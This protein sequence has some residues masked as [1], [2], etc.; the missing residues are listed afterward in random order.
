MVVLFGSLVLMAVLMLTSIRV[1]A[2][3]PD[4]DEDD[5]EREPEEPEEPEPTPDEEEPEG[6]PASE[7]KAGEVDKASRAFAEQRRTIAQQAREIEDLNSRFKTI[8]DGLQSVAGGKKP[9]EDRGQE[10]AKVEVNPHDPVN[11]PHKAAEWD[12]EQRKKL[13]DTID[14]R[15]KAR[16]RREFVA[17]RDNLSNAALDAFSEEYPEF[18][19]GGEGRKIIFNEAMRW[20]SRGVGNGEHDTL[21]VDD[22]RLICQ[23]FP[24]AAALIQSADRSNADSTVLTDINNAKYARPNRGAGIPKANLKDLTGAALTQLVEQA[25]E[26][27]GQ[28]AADEL[29]EKHLTPK[30]RAELFE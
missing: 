19:V 16:E 10:G 2:D 11:D 14:A 26:R 1:W 27:G 24:E 5:S 7:G 23:R 6:R 18:A 4:E 20:H 29:V 9:G 3:D 25:L 17:K 12:A 30:Q 13:L 21:T 22:V 8:V 15:E 28:E